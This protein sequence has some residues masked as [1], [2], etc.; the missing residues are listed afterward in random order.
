MSK[1]SLNFMLSGFRTLLT[2][3]KS[4]TDKIRKTRQHGRTN[5]NVHLRRNRGL[6]SMEP[7]S[8]EVFELQAMQRPGTFSCSV[9]RI[10]GCYALLL[11]LTSTVIQAASSTIII[12]GRH[13]GEHSLVAGVD[14]TGGGWPVH[15]VSAV[16]RTCL[17]RKSICPIINIMLSRKYL[18]LYCMHFLSPPSI[19]IP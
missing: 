4:L 2:L 13:A 19:T 1:V 3:D 10:L 16:H 8:H 6:L 12:Q 17:A 14:S 7:K 9:W 5:K 15:G 18:D 11:L